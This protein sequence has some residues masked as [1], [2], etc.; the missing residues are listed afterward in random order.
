MMMDRFHSLS[1][2]KVYE[3]MTIH[4][5]ENLLKM[6]QILSEVNG[7]LTDQNAPEAP[8][9]PENFDSDYV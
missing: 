7:I 3:S 1:I 9:F 6:K 8:N 4:H 2:D 5:F